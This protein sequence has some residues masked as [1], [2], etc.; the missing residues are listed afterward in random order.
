[1]YVQHM[2][3]HVMLHGWF[4]VMAE[5]TALRLRS[6]AY[7]LFLSIHWATSLIVGNVLHQLFYCTAL[8]V[9]IFMDVDV[10]FVQLY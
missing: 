5:V 9:M 8:Y 6:K 4:T 7:S 1:M 10:M 3:G 2:I